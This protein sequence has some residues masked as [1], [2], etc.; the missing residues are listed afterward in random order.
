MYPLFGDYKAVLGVAPTRRDVFPPREYALESKAKV[1]PRLYEI[2]GKIPDL[3]VVDLEG[4]CE[5]GLLMD[6]GEIDA[7]V[8]RFRER[9]VNALFLPHVNFGQEEAV[10][11]L[12]AALGVPTLLWGARD[13][14]PPENY[15]TRHTDT[16]CGL[17]VSGK[18]LSRRG[19]PFSYI[20]NCWLDSPKLEKGI[21]DFLGAATAARRLRALRVGQL[22]VRP[23][24]FLSVRVDENRLLERFG[25][26]V[27]AI[28]GAEVL[29]EVQ[30]VLRAR[31]GEFDAVVRDISEKA[32]CSAI[33]GGQLDKIAALECA[34][35]RLARRYNL[36]AL[37]ADCWH[38]FPDILGIVP[39]FA[40]GDTAEK[41]LPV[42]C[43]C[44]IHGAVSAAL[45]YA[46]SRGEGVPFLADL[47]IRHPQN[48][49]A[50][51][52]WHCGPFPKSLCKSGVTPAVV[53]C[54][55]Q[56]ELRGG[57]LTLCRFDDERGDYRLFV[58][59][60]A[61]TDGPP[62]GGNYLWI[63][64]ND[65]PAWERRLVCGP[66]IHHIAA[67]HGDWAE[68]LREACRLVGGLTPERV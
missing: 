9:G 1:M 58:E 22:S 45:L 39:C 38:T 59:N 57:T 55:G 56:Y 34:Y 32:D 21:R 37:A 11:K 53:D 41:G 35:L 6:L 3:E 44:D 18:A 4:V 29:E 49:N 67:I 26:D 5:D 8:R 13:D 15:A 68:P 46:V 62:T 23:R 12:A 28:T 20:E 63:E 47:T 2:F 61:G 66:Y 64:T 65:W 50:E 51:L 17:F 31:D 27:V 42:A 30:D 36:D 40:N 54:K 43:E 33:D 60:A 14:A 19:I 16:Q 25:I 10:A 52:L 48:D 24:Q 7:V